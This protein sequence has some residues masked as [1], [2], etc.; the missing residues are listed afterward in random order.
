MKTFIG[1]V[2][3]VF[4]LLVSNS[5]AHRDGCHRW[6][7]CPS[8]S[9]SYVCGDLGYYSECPN[10]PTQ[11]IATSTTSVT[12]NVASTGTYTVKSGDTLGKIAN[13]Y[14]LSVD[15]VAKANG[16]TN[17]NSIY[18]GQVLTLPANGVPFLDLTSP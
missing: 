10:K 16:I 4:G 13:S 12:R 7:S 8:D 18:V 11:Q 2:V 1:L 17:Y 9:G 5:Y 3:V 15:E 14:G 6:H